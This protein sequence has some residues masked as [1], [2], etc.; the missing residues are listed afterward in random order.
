MSFYK[1]EAG[2]LCWIYL[3][4]RLMP[5]PN[6]EQTTLQNQ[7]NVLY[8]LGDDDLVCPAPPLLLPPMPDLAHPPKPPTL[9]IVSYRAPCMPFRRNKVPYQ[10]L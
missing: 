7:N 10:P 2:R 5:L 8:L 1:V 6:V 3:V 4:G 9:T